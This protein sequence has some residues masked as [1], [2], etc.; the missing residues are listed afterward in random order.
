M[1]KYCTQTA[2]ITLLKMMYLIIMIECLHLCH[3]LSFVY[4]Y[5]D[6]YVDHKHRVQC[7]HIIPF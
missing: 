5:V 1:L 2:Y 6:E 4:I 7:S 3:M